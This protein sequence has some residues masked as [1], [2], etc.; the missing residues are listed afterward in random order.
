MIS[1]GADSNKI[2]VQLLKCSMVFC[3]YHFGRILVPDEVKT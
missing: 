2:N 3:E 1:D